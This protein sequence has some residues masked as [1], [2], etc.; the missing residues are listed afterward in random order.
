MAS[1]KGIELKGVRTFRGMEYPVNYQGNVYFNSK[2]LG[3]WSQD[4]N[5]GSDHYEFNTDDLDRVAK[6]YYGEDSIYDLDCLLGEVL[7]L[8]EYEKEYKK[9]IKEHFSAFVVISDGYEETAIKVPKDKDKEVIL[10]RCDS[11]IK[12]FEQNS[13]YKEDI[14]ISVYTDLADFVK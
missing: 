8:L 14:K 10:K 12:K 9:A 13:R 7:N 2:K 3:F 4:G 1:I 5:G 6:E 11:Y